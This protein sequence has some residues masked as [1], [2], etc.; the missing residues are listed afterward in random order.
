MNV[1]TMLS[2]GAQKCGDPLYLNFG[3]PEEMNLGA[4]HIKALKKLGVKVRPF[5]AKVIP[6][7]L[8]NNYY[9]SFIQLNEN[10][11]ADEYL[12]FCDGISNFEESDLWLILSD[13]VYH[14]LPPHKKYGMVIYDYVQKY[15]PQIMDDREWK[16]FSKRAAVTRSAEFVI[17]TTQQTCRDVISYAGVRPQQVHQFFM[18][19]TPPKFSAIPTEE[20]QGESY[21]LW[22]TILSFHEN[23]I[24]ILR[25]LTNFLEKNDFKVVINGPGVEMIHPN[26]HNRAGSNAY[27]DQIRAIIKNSSLLKDKLIIKGFIPDE[28]YRHLI[29]NAVCLLHSSAGDNGAYAP[30]EAAWLGIHSVSSLYP[31]ME[32]IAQR[33]NL[34]LVW[35]NA[36]KPQNLLEALT[37]AIEKKEFYR[38]LLPS[39]KYLSQFTCENLAFEYWKKFKTITTISELI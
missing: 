32:E 3:Y 9:D 27:I 6:G 26:Y 34:P 28:E 20:Q 23:H 29:Q 12:I 37:E 2:M 38:R 13:H 39:Q 18:D 10:S 21:I 15:Y 17:T 24:Y 14:P 11:R 7:I 22:S 33:F 30:I 36:N 19:F 31:A 8:L 35:Y 16:I 4:H 25:A 1:M 5:K